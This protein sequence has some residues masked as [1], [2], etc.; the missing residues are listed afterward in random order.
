VS[1]VLSWPIMW[2]RLSNFGPQAVSSSPP[3]KRIPIRF[4]P[5][6]E[7]RIALALTPFASPAFMGLFDPWSMRRRDAR[8]RLIGCYTWKH[9]EHA[10]YIKKHTP[11]CWRYTLDKEWEHLEMLRLFADRVHFYCEGQERISP[12]EKRE[13]SRWAPAQLQNF[14]AAN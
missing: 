7:S 1:D 10:C 9:E 13:I 8:D 2:I 4:T 5:L 3:S 14:E 11:P 12:P 6:I